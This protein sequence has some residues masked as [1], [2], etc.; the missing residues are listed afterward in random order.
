MENSEVIRKVGEPTDWVSSIVIVE[1]PN[2]TLRICLDPRNLNTAVK[3][4][5]FQ[6]PTIEEITSRISG[7]KVFSKLDADHG[8]RQLKLDSE[9]EL[10]T[11]FNTPFGRYCY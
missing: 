5:H 2:K 3:R 1:K 11:T 4:E 8:Y 6:L 9:S 10:F 7:A